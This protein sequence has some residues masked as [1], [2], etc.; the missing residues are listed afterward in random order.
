MF[1]TQCCSFCRR[2]TDYLG[3]CEL[4]YKASCD[5]CLASD[6]LCPDCAVGREALQSFAR[7]ALAVGLV[8]ATV[9]VVVV[10]WSRG[11]F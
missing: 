6:R 1:I 10:F 4:C 9:A 7:V 11:C 3:T 5:C 8:V 2:L